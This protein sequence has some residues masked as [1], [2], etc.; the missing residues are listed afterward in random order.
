ME[1]RDLKT[2]ADFRAVV[3]LEKLVWGFDADDVVPVPILVITVKRGGILIGAFDDRSEMTGFVYSLPGLKTGQPIQWSHMLGVVPSHR[4]AG[5][6]YRLKLEQRHRAL[7]QGLDLVEWTYDPLQALNAHFNFRKL[8]VVVEE[9][10][11]NVYGHTSSPLHRG[12]PTDRFV[13]QWWIRSSRVSGLVEGAPSS[14]TERDPW[15]VPA[16]NHAAPSGPWVRCEA[17]D[18]A[19][20]GPRLA[21]EIPAGFGDMLSDHPELAREWRTATREIFATYLGRGYRVVDFSLAP[22]RVRGRYVL[23]RDEG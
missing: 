1:L 17:V 2:L 5:L 12:N 14:A 11:Q 15:Q 16:V 18:L 21:V 20:S 10:G 9:Y 13:A 4:S 23:V 22:E 6:G 7:D 8:G 19:Q 3:E